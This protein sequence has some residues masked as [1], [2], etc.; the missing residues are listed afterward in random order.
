MITATN[1]LYSKAAIARMEGVEIEDVLR[2][3][4]WANVVFVIIRGRR[5]RFYS[6]QAFKVHFVQWRQAKARALTATQN[7]FNPNIF[8]VRNETK[9]TAYTVNFF[10]GGATCEC[11]DFDNQKNF[12]N[13]ACCKHIYAALDQLGFSSLRAY[14]EERKVIHKVIE[15]LPAA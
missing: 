10:T 4:V 7:L 13:I 12:F 14:I 9:R 5:P 3:E 15:S 1:L 11:D 8:Y 6:K 2:L